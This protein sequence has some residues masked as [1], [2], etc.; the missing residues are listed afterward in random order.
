MQLDNSTDGPEGVVQAI[1]AE[2]RRRLEHVV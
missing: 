1:L 2:Y